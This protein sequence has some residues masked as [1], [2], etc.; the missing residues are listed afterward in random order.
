MPN[1]ISLAGKV[2]L[3]TGGARGLGLALAE[4]M[5]LVGARVA[6]VDVKADLVRAAAKD[7]EAKA[8][9]AL[10]VAADVSGGHSVRVAVEAAVAAW[11]RVDVLVNTAGICPL[12]PP[13]EITEAEWDRVLAVNLKGTYLFSQ[14]VMP[15]MR[16]QH[17]GNI[18]NVT[19]SGA[20][21]GG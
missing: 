3:I 11:G 19:S 16:R 18:I 13:D 15:V 9:A 2:A 4:Q 10:P 5:A 17:S 7:L 8:Y 14:A 20:Q 6:P 1:T 21:T 12:T